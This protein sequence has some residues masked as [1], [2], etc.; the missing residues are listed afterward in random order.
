[1]TARRATHAGS[2]Y[3]ADGGKLDTELSS[4]LQSV[5]PSLEEA[6]APPVKGSKAIIAPH[7]GY[8]YSGSTAAWA[9]KS[10]DTAGIKR[11]FILGPA[12]H[13]YLDGCA[14]S[15]CERY[16]TPL[17]TLPL[18]LDTI[19]ELRDTG[20][21]SDMDVD[22][23]E[24]EHSIEMHLP[25]VRKIFEGLNIS[26]VPILVGAINYNK[27]A[28]FGTILAPYLARDDTFCVVSSDFCHWGTRFQYTFYYPK[29]PPTSIPAIRLSKADP[30]PPSLTTHPIYSSIS[31]LDHEAMELLTMPPSTAAQSHHEFAE[32]LA[33]TKNTI[34]GRHPIGVL[35]GA[36]AVLQKQGKVPH[37]KWV[38][39][40]QSSECV[41]IKD[42]SVSYASAYI[43]F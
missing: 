42:S 5:E 7:A 18:D 37:L 36:L 23:D 30:S 41:T 32:Y 10:I 24:D 14:L 33:R 25:Y 22:T 43:T 2:W 31:A 35:L 20:K 6:F 16:E 12:H 17:G 28:T 3:D 9:Y 15:T 11:V 27:E 1:M 26:I 29:A 34:C 13:V 19:Q 40:E 8:S 21:F 39:Y 4:N 38:R